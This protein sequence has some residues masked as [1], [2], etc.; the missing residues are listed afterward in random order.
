MP[1]VLVIE[2]EPNILSNT[3]DILRFEG[4]EVYGATNGRTGVEMAHQKRPDLIIC[5]IMMPECDGYQVL[6]A[7]SSNANTRSIP[8]IVMSARIDE[9]S[10]EH[11]I[12]RG[13]KDYLLKPFT[14]AEL[15]SVV[16]RYLND[17][18]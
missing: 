5:D 13:A 17:N 11:A 15:I 12:T 9:K 6:E 1:S 4:Y 8:F 18:A 3:I 2:D 14:L 16:R 10:L 7:L